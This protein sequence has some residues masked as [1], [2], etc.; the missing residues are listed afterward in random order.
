MQSGH[1]PHLPRPPFPTS[2]AKTPRTVLRLSV[3]R[4]T[5][6]EIPTMTHHPA[7]AGQTALVTGGSGAL[8]S[9]RA[10]FLLQDGGAVLLMGRR[11]D[12]LAKTKATLAEEFP[13]AT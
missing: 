10:R 1:H 11:P 4:A 7:L 8:G 3:P 12:A 6:G 13:T 5:P 9:A 2:L